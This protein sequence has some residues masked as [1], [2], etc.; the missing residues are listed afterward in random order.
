MGISDA[1]SSFTPNASAVL[2]LVS[3]SK[4]LLI[5]RMSTAQRNSIGSAGTGLMIYNTDLN[6]L[7]IYNGINYNSIGYNGTR[8]F[9]AGANAGATLSTGTHIV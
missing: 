9:F 1:G 3:T 4:G 6:S 8:N 7:D 2:E 5:P